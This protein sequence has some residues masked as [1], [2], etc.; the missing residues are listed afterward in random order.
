MKFMHHKDSKKGNLS[1]SISEVVLTT[2][3]AIPFRIYGQDFDRSLCYYTAA[4]H[5]NA[6]KQG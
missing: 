2:N 4:L 1:T 6:N 3:A 5:L